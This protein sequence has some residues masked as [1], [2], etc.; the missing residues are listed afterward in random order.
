MH[1]AMRAI[2]RG[3]LAGTAATATMSIAM[4]LAQRAG[5][6]GRMPPKKITAAALRALGVRP[7]EPALDAATVAAHVGFGASVGALYACGRQR[8]PG[9][10]PAL[11]G[12]VF[13]TVVWAVS[14][15]GWVPALGIMPMPRHDRPGRPT[16]MLVAHWIYGATLGAVDAWLASPV[17]GAHLAPARPARL[18]A[19]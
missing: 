4:G 17:A 16:S 7:P 12:A 1:S 8:L 6:L 9:P 5:L 10:S 13:G 15:Q 14:Y 3:A 19:P 11:A 18:P 2:V